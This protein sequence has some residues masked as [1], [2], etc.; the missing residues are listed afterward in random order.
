MAWAM[1]TLTG[2]GDDLAQLAHPGGDRCHVGRPGQVG[3]ARG[4]FGRRDVLHRTGHDELVN[5][6]D[7]LFR[8]VITTFACGS[9]RR[10]PALCGLRFLLR[11]GG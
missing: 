4:K 9:F 5:R 8:S 3:D 6:H 7:D 1:S 2:R 10:R 11:V